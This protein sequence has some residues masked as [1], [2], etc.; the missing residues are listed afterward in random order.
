MKVELLNRA[1]L[2]ES[3]HRGGQ[4]SAVAVGVVQ[5]Q[6]RSFGESLIPGASFDLF[7]EVRFL[8]N[9]IEKAD[10][11]VVAINRRPRLLILY[12]LPDDLR[13]AVHSRVAVADEQ[14]AEIGGTNP[15]KVGGVSDGGRR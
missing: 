1:G 12:H 14:N 15:L 13:Q 3:G 4:S 2:C 6:V 11:N 5:F 7:A 9:L 10:R 8:R